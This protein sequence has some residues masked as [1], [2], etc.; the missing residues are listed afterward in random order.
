MKLSARLKEFAERNYQLK[1]KQVEDEHR[2]RESEIP[3][4]SLTPNGDSLRVSKLLPLKLRAKGQA[5]ID[6]YLEAFELEGK[7]PERDDQ[8]DIDKKLENI[9]RG[10]FGDHTGSLGIGT[11]HEIQGI[12]KELCEEMRLR[13]ERMALQ[14]QRGTGMEKLKIRWSQLP[15]ITKPKIYRVPGIGDVD[16]TAEAIE[17]AKTIGGDPWIELHDTTT[18]G[19]SVRQYTI[20]LFTPA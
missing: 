6:C 11:F 7:A 12:E 3:A 1:A 17:N 10:G 14:Y 8:V 4:H 5:V 9:F 20:G 18:F 16:V 19:H 13:A 2:K 15:K